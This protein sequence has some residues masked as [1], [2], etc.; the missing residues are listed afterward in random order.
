MA[1]SR[2]KATNMSD[3]VVILDASAADTDVGERLLLDGT[4]GSATDA[5]FAVLSEPHT[6]SMAGRQDDPAGTVLQMVKAKQD[7]NMT[8][9]SNGQSYFDTG[10][11]FRIYP[12]R[13][14]SSFL[15]NWYSH[16]GQST[17]NNYITFAL[18]RS[19]NGATAVQIADQYNFGGSG[20]STAGRPYETR[21]MCF[22]DEPPSGGY[23]LGQYIEYSIYAQNSGGNTTYFYYYNE[24]NN[25]QVH[26]YGGNGA[27]GWIAEI[28]KSSMASGGQASTSH[29]ANY[30]QPG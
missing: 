24:Q 11:G 25:P 13:L 27:G 30:K 1:L 5:G 10:V 4:D 6:A 8:V 18:Y 21:S 23:T 9:S 3:D 2:I 19:L 7:K 14:D 16:H 17:H 26:I 22:M 12:K 28:E 20:S 29:I 15:V